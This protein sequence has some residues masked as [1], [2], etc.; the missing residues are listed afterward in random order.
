MLSQ[1][2]IEEC[3]RVGQARRHQSRERI[4][5]W[6]HSQQCTIGYPYISGPDAAEA[7]A[8]VL[9]AAGKKARR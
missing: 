6:F 7:L 5:S 4:E 9:L 8:R 3:V 1:V 2:V